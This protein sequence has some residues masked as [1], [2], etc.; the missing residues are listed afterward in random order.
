MWLV[1]ALFLYGILNESLCTKHLKSSRINPYNSKYK[2]FGESKVL[3]LDT[4]SNM[5]SKYGTN[6]FII[7]AI[8]E[9]TEIIA[10]Q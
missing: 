10:D 9:K 7:S 6:V 8:N 1:G 4:R 2:D 5:T 3:D